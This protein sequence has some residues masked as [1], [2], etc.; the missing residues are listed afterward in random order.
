MHYSQQHCCGGQQ[1]IWGAPSETSSKHAQCSQQDVWNPSSYSQ[2]VYQPGQ[3]AVEQYS[4]IPRSNGQL[5][6]ALHHKLA[7]EDLGDMEVLMRC[8]KIRTLRALETL[9]TT[10]RAVLL[11][12]AREF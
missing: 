5:S 8:R 2:L 6:P 10:E 1:N 11:C 9:E 4:D 12:K 7:E 3:S